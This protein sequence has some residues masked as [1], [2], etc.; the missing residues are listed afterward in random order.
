[1][2]RT[3]AV[4]IA[5]ILS[6]LL[7]ACSSIRT[8]GTPRG[9]VPRVA[10]A[11][12]PAAAADPGRWEIIPLEVHEFDDNNGWKIVRIPIN[13]MNK[14]DTFTSAVITTT[15]ARLLT[16][17][18]KQNGVML[19]DNMS[20]SYPVRLFESTGSVPIT[21]TVIDYTAGGPVPPH[22]MLAGIYENDAVSSYYFESRI[23]TRAA[24]ARIIIPGYLNSI[25][26]GPVKPTTSYAFNGVSQLMRKVEIPGKAEL[27]VVNMSI[28]RLPQDAYNH[29][30]HDRLSAR[31]TLTST[32]KGD[33]TV[34]NLRV[35]AI[36]DKSI[37]GTPITDTVVGCNSSPFTIGPSQR[38][39][40]TLC[41]ILPYQSSNIRVILTGDIYDFFEPG[42]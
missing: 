8:L 26:L 14:T 22:F 13:V 23:P 34:V 21:R 10:A 5:L 18:A 15:E 20:F 1:M 38:I 3:S 12:A 30:A 27:Q 7:I 37:L 39:T 17:A 35:S 33:D 16:V 9:A 41:S 40:R 11:A 42:F 25:E 6:D 2:R 36:G 32:N 19:D 24:P 28:L 4:L 29:T 31:L